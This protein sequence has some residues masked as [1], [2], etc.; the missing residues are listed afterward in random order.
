MNCYFCQSYQPE[1]SIHVMLCQQC[2]REVFNKTTSRGTN[3][4][5][6]MYVDNYTIGL[7]IEDQS[8]FILETDT[9]KYLLNL[10]YIPNITPYNV[11]QYVEKLLNLKVFL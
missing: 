8:C 9:Q 1:N 3:L 10:D 4:L 6:C 11:E 2:P 7:S 5:V